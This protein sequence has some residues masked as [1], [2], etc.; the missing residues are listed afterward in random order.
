MTAA[1]RTPNT[2]E[3]V[4]VS[5]RVRRDIEDA[6]DF[7]TRDIG[8]WWPLDRFSFGGERASEVH[9][10]P[11]EGGRLY[12]R[13]VDGEEHGIGRVLRWEAPRVVVFTW[14]H[15]DWVADTQIEVRFVAEEANVTR[16]ELEHR[17]WDRLGPIDGWQRDDYNNGW[18]TVIGCFQAAAGAA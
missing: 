3:P 17:D 1:D 7:F 10:E 6:F 12:E 13:Y 15:P 2:I 11:Y 9:F 14:R 4:R 16:I 18:P 5:A 8:S